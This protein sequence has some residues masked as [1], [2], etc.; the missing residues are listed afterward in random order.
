MLGEKFIILLKLQIFLFYL[1]IQIFVKQRHILVQTLSCIYYYV[2]RVISIFFVFQQVIF[3][4]TT[5][6]SRRQ[7]FPLQCQIQYFNIFTLFVFFPV[8][9][10]K[11]IYKSYFV[12]TV[13]PYIKLQIVLY[14][15][16]IFYEYCC[17][18]SNVCACDIIQLHT[19]IDR[20]ITCLF[21]HT[22]IYMLNNSV[23][24]VCFSLDIYLKGLILNQ[25]RKFYIRFLIFDGIYV[26]QSFHFYNFCQSLHLNYSLLII[27][28]ET[29]TKIKQ[30]L[31]RKLQN[32]YLKAQLVVQNQ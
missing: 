19:I 29:K 20:F 9:L 8:F 4:N 1:H 15:L 22:C 31:F 10:V 3:Q 30:F 21:Q 24:H 6:F 26:G 5:I 28:Q 17:F 7:L 25:N 12:F 27:L 13:Q 18:C 11:R 16:D 23:R 32:Y 14:N 2:I